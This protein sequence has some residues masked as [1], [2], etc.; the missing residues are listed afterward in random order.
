MERRG[1][2]LILILLGLLAGAL[3]CV[4]SESSKPDA[5]P[6]IID[7]AGTNDGPAADL[8]AGGA[9]IDAGGLAF[10]QPCT[11]DNMCASDVCFIGGSRSFCSMHCDAGTDCPDP[12]SDGTCNMQ[13][14]C[15]AP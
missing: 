2:I 8:D 10:G 6:A 3:A 4:S 1:T 15:R 7:A 9:T 13:G 14:Y 12:P 5:A 11:A